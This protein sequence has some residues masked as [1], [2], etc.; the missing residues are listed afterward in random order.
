NIQFQFEKIDL[1]E[2][3]QDTAEKLEPHALQKQ[4]KLTVT[5]QKAEISGVRQIL[6]EIVF[7]LCDNAIKYNHNNGTVNVTVSTSGK[8]VILAVKDSG[9]GIPEE[10]QSRIF[11]RFYRVDKSHSRDTG[12]TGLGLSIVKHGVEF[13]NAKIKLSSEPGKG[14]TVKIIFN[15]Q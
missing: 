15:K 3:A 6:Q 7:N 9:F 13:H 2:L 5:G 4:I 10:H 11:E 1:L 14:T 8:D 12:G